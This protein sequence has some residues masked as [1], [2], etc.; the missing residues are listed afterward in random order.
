MIRYSAVV[1]NLTESFQ[2][3]YDKLVA[4][5][6]PYSGLSSSLNNALDGLQERF[7]GADSLLSQFQAEV[8][9]IESNF[10]LKL[11]AENIASTVAAVQSNASVIAQSSVEVRIIYSIYPIFYFT[12][13]MLLY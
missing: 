6:P 9:S 10:E 5:V 4:S 2:T 3:A 11:R 7:A 8:E 13:I 1:G 12:A